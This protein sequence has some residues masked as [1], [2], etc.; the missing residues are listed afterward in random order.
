MWDSV[1]DSCQKKA[2]HASKMVE[3]VQRPVTEEDS[4]ANAIPYVEGF[5]GPDFGVY[6]FC[7]PNRIR[8]SPDTSLGFQRVYVFL[9]I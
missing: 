2:E 6:E 8:L 1:V 3:R 5:A 4:E 9:H 7:L